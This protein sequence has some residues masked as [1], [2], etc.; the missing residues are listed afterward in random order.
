M[1]NDYSRERNR[2][3][4]ISGEQLSNMKA[5]SGDWWDTG[6]SPSGPVQQVI[7]DDKIKAPPELAGLTG[8]ALRKAL[9]AQ[10]REERRLGDLDEVLD[11]M[12]IE[13]RYG[14]DNWGAF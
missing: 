8:K 14:A 4:R 10:R 2:W 7:R 5:P 11:Q 1:R 3:D 6:Y 13:E 9:K 12:V